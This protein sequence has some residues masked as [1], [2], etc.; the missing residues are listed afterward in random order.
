MA[1][2]SILSSTPS[3]INAPLEVHFG[4][5]R[6]MLL[7][8]FGARGLANGSAPLNERPVMAGPRVTVVQMGENA[9]K[10]Y[11]TMFRPGEFSFRSK[12]LE[13]LVGSPSPP[14]L[15]T[16]TEANR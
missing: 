4:G 13:E 5:I 1:L 6:S 11:A 15:E 9:R 8:A 7:R 14:P 16:T 10:A 3:N 2:V 12:G